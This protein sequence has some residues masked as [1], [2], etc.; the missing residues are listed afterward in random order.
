MTENYKQ[1]D[2][3]ELYQWFVIEQD[4]EPD[5]DKLRD[6]GI[7]GTT[8]ELLLDDEDQL[9]EI[10]LGSPNSKKKALDALANLLQR[11]AEQQERDDPVQAEEEKKEEEKKDEPEEAQI[12]ER[13]QIQPQPDVLNAEV[14]EAPKDLVM[15]K[16]MWL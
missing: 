1:W 8:I 14:E 4:L 2:N 9:D 3:D 10:G 7:D 5:E 11:E 15:K 12:H 6:A 13:D 16:E